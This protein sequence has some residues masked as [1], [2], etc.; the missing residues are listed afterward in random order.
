MAKD[1]RQ[2]STG[3]V[4][5]AGMKD[6]QPLV[7]DPNYYSVQGVHSVS[8]RY[9]QRIE[10][11]NLMNYFAVPILAIHG[12]QKDHIFVETTDA[13]YIFDKIDDPIPT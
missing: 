7:A 5:P 9:L 8:Q 4:P 2:T 6:N 11:K 12:D 13:I 3:I 10:S 1:T